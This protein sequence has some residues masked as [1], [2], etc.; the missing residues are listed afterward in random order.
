[1]LEPIRPLARIHEDQEIGQPEALLLQKAPERFVAATP[2]QPG[3]PASNGV[4]LGV[5]N[6]T[7]LVLIEVERLQ[8]PLFPNDLIHLPKE[9][10][11]F[12]GKTVLGARRNGRAAHCLAAFRLIERLTLYCSGRII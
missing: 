2:Q 1:G 9:V 5:V 8:A 3:I 6:H 10:A 12:G 7:I 4:A 11:W